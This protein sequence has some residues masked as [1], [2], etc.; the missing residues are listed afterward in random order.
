VQGL[1]KNLT[2]R[3]RILLVTPYLPWPLNTGGNA[4]I[5]STLKC[6]M[7]DHEFTVVSLLQSPKQKPHLGPLRLALPGIRFIPVETWAQNSGRFS[8][9]PAFRAARIFY[10]A[11]REVV[12]H[13]G[14]AAPLPYYPFNPLP[15]KLIQIINEEIKKGVDICQVEFAEMMPLGAWLPPELPKVLIHHQIHFMYA[16]RFIQTQGD[17]G[18][19]GRFLEATM[20]AQE[21]AFLKC[22]DTVVTMSKEDCDILRPHLNGVE[23]VAS[24]S[25]CP[26]DI[27]ITATP[28]APFNG[29]FSF[30]AS[31][32][33]L[34]NRDALVWLLEEIWPKISAALPS[35]RLNIIG[36]WSEKRRN[37]LA[38]PGLKFTGFVPD[39]A[40][41]V[42][43]SV[44]LVPVRIGSGI[45][46][47]IVAAQ[48][49]GAPVVTTRIGGE[50]LIGEDG[51]EM[52][53]RD[54]ADDFAAAAVELARQPALWQK[55]C[56]AGKETVRKNY[57]PE[58][59]RARRNEIYRRLRTVP[60][61]GN[62]PEKVP[63]P[64]SL[65]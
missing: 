5:F 49:L 3:M 52:L 46:L 2:S 20:R 63:A 38:G 42:P 1:E 59:L 54:S 27:Q 8:N 4:G 50:G 11:S 44:M 33:H 14:K 18:G 53:I 43:G 61:A 15:A 25:P 45:R 40:S 60:P 10:R 26:A 57:S 48:A 32:A 36:E 37:E 62:K 13:P 58:S 47:K 7:A 51:R 30:I 29:T 41:V 24:P 28:P 56:A 34:P 65:L 64:A 23:L 55:L 22:F 9:N 17:A 39:L 12:L 21:I 6:L 19:Y 16:Q 35:A 31:E